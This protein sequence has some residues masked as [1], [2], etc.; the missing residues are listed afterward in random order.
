MTVHYAVAELT[1]PLAEPYA[2]VR[3]DT[4]RR[5]GT[6]VKGRIESLHWSAMDA[7]R[8]AT[9]LTDARAAHEAQEKGDPT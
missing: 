6:G 4:G 2:V 1:D 3:I 5:I 8:A 7:E 9:D